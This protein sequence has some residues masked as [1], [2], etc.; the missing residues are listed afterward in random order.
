M[1]ILNFVYIVALNIQKRVLLFI[2]VFLIDFGND[3]KWQND[4]TGVVLQ[5]FSF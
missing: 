2:V 3:K 4:V 5:T 1:V